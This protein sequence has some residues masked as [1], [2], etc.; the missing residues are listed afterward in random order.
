MP[1]SAL[2]LYD[3]LHDPALEILDQLQDAIRARVAVVMDYHSVQDTVTQRQVL[4]AAV[5]FSGHG[6]MLGA[7]CNLRDDLRTFRVDRI[8]YMHTGARFSAARAR[9]I[10]AALTA[11]RRQPR[12]EYSINSV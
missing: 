6:W 7:W 12:S 4:P 5:F 3:P 9:Q 1:E 10:R 11:A 8:T 2:P